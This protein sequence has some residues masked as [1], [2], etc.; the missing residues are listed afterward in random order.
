M[1][2]SFERIF[3]YLLLIK[4]VFLALMIISV[5]ALSILYLVS[6]ELTIGWW[7]LAPLLLPGLVLT[8][9]F[10]SRIDAGK[11]ETW[12]PPIFYLESVYTIVISIMFFAGPMHDIALVFGSH[13]RFPALG[14][15]GTMPIINHITVPLTLFLPP[16]IYGLYFFVYTRKRG[17]S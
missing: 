15:D 1:K 4:A 16:L 10:R 2:T 13:G 3:G 12:T 7:I 9:A 14:L 11:I 6:Y 5:S 8:L 17:G